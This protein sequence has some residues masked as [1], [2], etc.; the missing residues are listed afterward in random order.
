MPGHTAAARR[1]L[2]GAAALA[3][4]VFV[5][6]LYVG[7]RPLVER[8]HHFI[9]YG[10]RPADLHL[11]VRLVAARDPP[12]PQPVLHARDLGA[13]RP[14]PH[15]GDDVPGLA[16]AFAPRDA[17][18]RRDRSP[19]TSPRMLLPALA[20]W[21]AFLLCRHLTRRALA[22]AR[23]RLPLRLLELP[24]RAGRLRRP[25]PPDGRLPAPARRAR[26]PSLPRRRRA[27]VGP[28]LAPGPAPRPAGATSPPRWR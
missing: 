12:R 16:L 19:T 15:L 21:T 7:L 23:R 8:G 26:D 10:Y 28:R 27:R 2:A 14:Q 24:A 4:Y 22:L 17:A 13:G 11:V 9:G 6:F 5:S 1:R 25:P 3:G 20:A 18:L